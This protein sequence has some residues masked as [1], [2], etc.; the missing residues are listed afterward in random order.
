MKTNDWSRRDFL[1]T[2]SAATLSALA[3]G[4]PRA[5]QAAEPLETIKPTADTVIVLWMGGGMAHTETFDPKRYAPFEKGMKPDSMFCTF[6][7][8]DTAVDHIKFSQ[9][10][11]RVAKVIDRGS[12]IRS[13]TAGDLGFILHSRHQYQWHTGY[14]PPQTVAAPHLG[15]IIARTLGP[16]N[17]A[18]PAFIN[19]GQR[20]DVGEGEELKAFSTAGFLGSEFGPFNIPYPHQAADAVRPPSGMSPDRFEDRNKHYKKLLA[21]SPIGEFGSD[22]QKESLV[23]SLDNAHRLLSS[24]AAKAFDLSLEPKESLQK[25]LPEGVDPGQAVSAKETRDGSYEAQTLGRFGLGCVL[26]R[27]LAEVGARYI[28]VTTEYIPFLNWDTHEHGHE[29]LVNMKKQIDGAVS[30]LVLDLEA[31]GLLNRTLVVLASEFSRDALIEGKPDKKVK[32]QVPV[33]DT[34]EDLKNYGMHRHFTDAGCVLLFG[35]GIKKG[36][37]HGLTADERPFK[38]IKDRV[39]I[40]DLHATIFRAVGI[41]ARQA[42]EVEKR[43]FY[44]T[45][46]GLGK[47]IM[48]LFG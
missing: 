15:A 5:V 23:R 7:T 29:K 22:Y 45:R 18:V 25:Y 12:L 36:N 20:F 48:N 32:D 17:P 2:S 37:L 33:P 24:P 43:P 9:G 11:E 19:I 30:Q 6:P 47:P 21:A 13:Y 3:A 27:R 14:A 42:Y 46:D 8:I 4:Y 26:A 41:S 44:V 1:K 16:L 39:V 35:G 38:T 40:E 28:E 10:L 34:I 31:R